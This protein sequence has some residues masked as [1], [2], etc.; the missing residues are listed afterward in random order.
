[1]DTETATTPAEPPVQVVFRGKKR[2]AYRQRT[3]TEDNDI[4]S[5]NND[6]SPALT[7]VDQARNT[8]VPAND[9]SP[10]SPSNAIDAITVPQGSR[11]DESA[12]EDEKGLSVA[13]VLR[14]RNVR[15]SRLG[16]VKFSATD[17]ALLGAGSAAGGEYNGNATS[18]NNDDLSLMIREEESRV[19]ERSST[20]AAGVN[21]RFAPQTGL[22]S[23]LINKHMEEYIEAKL[24][25]RHS[26]AIAAAEASS[27]SIHT[28]QQQQHDRTFA[29][30]YD[31]DDEDDED[32]DGDKH[33]IAK[34]FAEYAGKLTNTSQPPERHTALQG[35]LMEVDLGEEVR[36]RNAAMTERARRRLLGEAVP[37]DDDDD[38]GTAQHQRSGGRPTK[39][40]LGRDGKPWRPRN[41]RGSDDV[42]R[43]QLVE[44]ILHENRL[45]VY[46]PPTTSTSETPGGVA[47]A[48][49]AAA[50]DGSG[51]NAAADAI[52]PEDAADDRIAEQFRREFMEAMAERRQRRKKAPLPPSKASAA[53]SKK[54][55][56]EIL[57]GPKLGG[58]RNA[59]AAMRDILLKQQEERKA[60]QPGGGS[61]RGGRR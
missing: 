15:K 39:V 49:A 57:R 61:S 4:N 42:K 44:A 24:A 11:E 54:E 37:D 7:A 47:G 6:A 32:E 26:A 14:R 41:R 55:S 51:H 9:P 20:A 29:N 34:I 58:S 25:K 3:E 5:S 2:K 35:K 53:A 17:S 1:M 38:G 36:S 28:A 56:D 45:D 48:G 10:A 33:A 27:S 52:N 8:S 12:A 60:L 30:K 22:S 13:E 43:D 50:A 46:E 21:R 18:S 31:D 19:I 40:R 23:E 16:G 59:R